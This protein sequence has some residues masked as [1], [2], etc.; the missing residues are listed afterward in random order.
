MALVNHS[1]KLDTFVPAKQYFEDAQCPSE[2]IDEVLT[3]EGEWRDFCE[4]E[5]DFYS[6]SPQ[7]L[8]SE[9]RRCFNRVYGLA[10]GSLDHIFDFG[11]NRHDLEH[12]DHVADNT[13]LLLEAAGY[14]YEVQRRGVAAARGHDLGNPL[15]RKLHSLVS[16]RIFRKVIQQVESDPKQWRI[17][18]R[19]MQLHNEPIASHLINSWSKEQGRKL[20]D[21]EII[22]KMR[23]DFGPEALAL[24]IADKT[25][26]GRHRIS[27]KPKDRDAVNGDP[28]LEVNLLGKTEKLQV[29]EDKKTFTWNLLFTPGMSKEE[30]ENDSRFAKESTKHPEGF[31]ARVSDETHAL[32]REHRIPHMDRWKSLFWSLYFERI[33]LTIRSAF[34]LYP[35]LEKFKINIEDAEGLESLE[36]TFTPEKM[37]ALFERLVIKYRLDSDK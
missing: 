9:L 25:D 2:F 18:R 7:Q 29:S 10:N 14:G 6:I 28:H 22:E 23:T 16:P 35:D 12:I 32:H 15:T 19:A 13:L 17:I 21:T 24:I 20:S 36:Y 3:P 5:Y 11:F 8:N 4:D 33:V 30:Q 27:E 34:A 37:G 1:G 26:I 31:R